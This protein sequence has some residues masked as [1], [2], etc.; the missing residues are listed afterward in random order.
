MTT[1]RRAFLSC[2]AISAIALLWLAASA[3]VTRR[4]RECQTNIERLSTVAGTIVLTNREP[5]RSAAR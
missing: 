1:R 4:A 5:E 3:W 2:S